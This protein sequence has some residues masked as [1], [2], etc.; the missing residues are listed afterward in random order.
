MPKVQFSPTLPVTC[1]LSF[2][3]DLS[4]INVICWTEIGTDFD[5]DGNMDPG[6][7]LTSGSFAD[8]QK[9]IGVGSDFV[10]R[11]TDIIVLYKH[12]PGS[13]STSITAT[14]SQNGVVMPQGTATRP[15]PKTKEPGPVVFRFWD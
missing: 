2:D 5:G 13:T 3:G 15:A 4:S 6:S 12:N 1:Q 7:V 14:L 11:V 9:E 8:L 10:H